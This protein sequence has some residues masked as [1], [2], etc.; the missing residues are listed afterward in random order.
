MHEI[1]EPV[2]QYSTVTA[3]DDPTDPTSIAPRGLTRVDPATYAIAGCEL[4]RSSGAATGVVVAG[5]VVAGVAGA[6]GE[7]AV[8]HAGQEADGPLA[9]AVAQTKAGASATGA[10][11]PSSRRR[12]RAPLTP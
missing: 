11:T 10:S 2:C 1:G 8:T 5:V 6:A 7:G 12:W 9:S 4:A 3:V